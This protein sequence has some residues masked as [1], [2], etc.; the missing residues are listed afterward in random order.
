MLLFDNRYS[1]TANQ[2]TEFR[3]KFSCIVLVGAEDIKKN[4]I[5]KQLEN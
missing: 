3:F 4:R 1:K 2:I 5:C